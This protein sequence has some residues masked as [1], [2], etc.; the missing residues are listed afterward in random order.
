MF[1]KRKSKRCR[2][3]LVIDIERWMTDPHSSDDKIAEGIALS[4][5]LLMTTIAIAIYHQMQMNNIHQEILLP[6]RER[7]DGDG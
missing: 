3:K 5:R 2:P 6:A 7:L 4:A 1:W